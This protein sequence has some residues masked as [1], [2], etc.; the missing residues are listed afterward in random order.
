MKLLSKFTTRLM[1]GY[2]AEESGNDSSDL[3][4]EGSPLSVVARGVD[5]GF[6]VE[7]HVDNKI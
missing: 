4:R 1:F 2:E 7:I 5:L 6:S 3:E